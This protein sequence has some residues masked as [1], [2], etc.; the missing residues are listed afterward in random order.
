ML[1]GNQRGDVLDVDGTDANGFFRGFAWG[2]DEVRTVGSH[3]LIHLLRHR[4]ADRGQAEQGRSAYKHGDHSHDRAGASTEHRAPQHGGEHFPIGHRCTA[5][6]ECTISD[7]E[8]PPPVL[9]RES[10]EWMR[11]MPTVW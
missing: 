3:F 4:N 6:A 5:I 2:D 1:A 10:N 7:H 11:T 9:A 8:A